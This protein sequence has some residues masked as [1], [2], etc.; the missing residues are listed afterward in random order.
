M[1]GFVGAI[2]LEGEVSRELR[3][4]ALNTIAHR[5]PDAVGEFVE[6]DRWLGFRR[7][8][9]L[10]LA[11]RADQPMEHPSGVRL[12]FN[13]EI[14][15]FTELRSQLED[16]GHRFATTGDTEV[17]LAGY[18]EW[19]DD[20]FTKCNGM[21]AVA[22]F[23]PKRG[24]VLLSRD[25]FGE[26]P[27]YLGQDQKGAW[28]FASEPAALRAAKVGSG[29]LDLSAA[30]GLFYYGDTD[31]GTRTWFDGIEQVPPGH[32]VHLQQSGRKVRSFWSIADEIVT[33]RELG[34]ASDLEVRDALTR[35]V[36]IRLRSDVAVGTSL[37]GGVDSTSVLAC[38]REVDPNRQLHAFT[39]SFPGHP[40]D[41]FERARSV[42]ER[43]D[44]EI[45][46][47]LPTVDDFIADLDDLILHQGG[48]FD[49][50]SVH[51]QWCVMRT[52]HAHG[53]TVLLDGQGADETWGGYAKYAAL[54]LADELRSGNFSAL[55]ATMRSPH[56]R[57][58]VRGG[59]SP[60][61]A[62]YLLPDALRSPLL[63]LLRKQRQASVGPALGN[64][65]PDDPIGSTATSNGP[66]GSAQTGDI[67]RSILP[68][69][70]RYADRN[71]MAWS[72]EV[73]LPFLDPEMT[74]LG[75]RSTWADGATHGWT[76]H[77]L[78]RAMDPLLPHDV[79]WNRT[80]SAFDV[81][82][83]QWLTNP[84]LLEEIASARQRLAEVGLLAS[85]PE[86][87]DNPWITLSLDRLID[88]YSLTV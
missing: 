83:E 78:R 71:S 24:G 80:K 55:A 87:F 51:A 14:Y 82:T 85:G 12:V 37:S 19:G 47:V 53:V 8:S 67:G 20:V 32:I 11:A 50:P 72:R 49:L 75:L 25:R 15:N 63:G 54:A 65:V 68:R 74:S 28:W 42:A 35:S 2:G 16:K 52:A 38:I 59:V 5:G 18:V 31:P 41:E 84:K 10:D 17:L 23:D 34:A 64:V 60:K 56:G 69:L 61:L 26:K 39:V 4:R 57:Q 76:K 6:Q 29:R 1:C 62:G 9:I 73:R 33:A 7:L 43:Y 79:L 44:V 21:W 36:E 81:P 30:A 45:V 88:L 13:G 77:Q 70:L 3:Q 22:I 58:A 66:L 86:H 48:P 46:R 40:G 27:L